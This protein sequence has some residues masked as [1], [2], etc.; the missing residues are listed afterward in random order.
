MDHTINVVVRRSQ[1][2]SPGKFVRQIAPVTDCQR[3]R[4]AEQ[5][6]KL[7]EE[8][9]RP[10]KT[11]L[12]S[13]SHEFRSPISAITSAADILS[14]ARDPSL[15]RVPWS[16]VDEIQ[17]ASRRLNRLVGNVLAMARLEPGHVK[18]RLDWCD[19]TDLIQVTFRDRIYGRPQEE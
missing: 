19:V 14:A 17:E 8:S 7:I 5:R 4:A 2:D 3:L 18:P 10:T 1:R 16:M 15:K 9:E 11:L 12:D 13:I 6:M